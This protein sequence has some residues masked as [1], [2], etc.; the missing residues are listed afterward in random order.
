MLCYNPVD[1]INVETITNDVIRTGKKK[2]IVFNELEWE[3]RQFTPEFIEF[4]KINNVDLEIIFGSAYDEYYDWYAELLN[5]DPSKLTF[6]KTYWI[7]WT[8]MCLRNLIDHTTHTVDTNFKYPFIC[9]NNKNHKHRAALIDH[10]TKYNLLDKGIV[11]WHKFSNAMHG[12]EFK[13]YDDSIRT[14]DDDFVTKLDS[15]LLPPQWHESFFH[16]VGEATINAQFVT[17]K[18]II[19]MLLKKPFVSMAKKGFNKVLLDLGFKQYDEIIDYSFDNY[20]DVADRADILCR[21]IS[22]MDNNYKEL[23][24]LLRPKI[25]YNYNRCLEI[26]KDKK[27][28][29]KQVFDRVNYMKSLDYIP[30]HTDP[31]Y[32]CIVEELN[33]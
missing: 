10:I 12:Y 30:M 3:L 20:D 14:I 28:I 15:F 25:E 23:Y 33:D 29:P 6:W 19:P 22:N 8:E 13:Y 32:E 16:V 5:I 18:T 1:D 2:V 31:R 21:S 24:E 26:I 11:T 9:L 27:F 7:N 17:E 4:L